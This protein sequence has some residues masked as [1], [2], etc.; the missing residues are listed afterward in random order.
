MGKIGAYLQ[1]DD[2][3]AIFPALEEIKLLMSRWAIHHLGEDYQRHAAQALAAFDPF[4]S[5]RANKLVAL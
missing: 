4:I 5:A 1:H 3:E 2:G